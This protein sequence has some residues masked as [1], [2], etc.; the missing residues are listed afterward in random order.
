MTRPHSAL[1]LHAIGWKKNGFRVYKTRAAQSQRTRRLCGRTSRSGRK[2]A[3]Q[4]SGNV[5]GLP[6]T[7]GRRQA[8][9][10]AGLLC[11]H[12]CSLSKVARWRTQ[13]TARRC[14][15]CSSVCYSFGVGE[16]GV[17]GVAAAVCSVRDGVRS[18]LAGHESFAADAAVLI[19]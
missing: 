9:L 15:R 16:C 8:C 4:S 12:A 11:A 7:I 14:R 18:V 19:R 6:W 13:P 5:S 17:S 2:S 10:S 3:R 1:R